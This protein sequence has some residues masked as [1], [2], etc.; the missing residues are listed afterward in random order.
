MKIIF[1]RFLRFPP[2]TGAMTKRA[3]IFTRTTA[4]SGAND[5]I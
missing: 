4:I 3:P 2:G 1:I 5:P